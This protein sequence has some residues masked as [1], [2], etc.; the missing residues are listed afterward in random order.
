M[1]K[2][3]NVY[4]NPDDVAAMYPSAHEEGKI[5]IVLKGGNRVYVFADIEEVKRTLESVSVLF[6]DSETI[7]ALEL[8][9]D[10]YRF[11][12]RD[13]GGRVCAFEK[14]PTQS[15]DGLWYSDS[16]KMCEVQTDIF[17]HV[18]EDDLVPLLLYDFLRGE[19]A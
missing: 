11:L 7:R 5:W 8:Y 15:D 3:G 9:N 12:A 13:D 2:I 1:I 18:D 14:R 19:G 6:D 17:R 16:G 4:I 10:G